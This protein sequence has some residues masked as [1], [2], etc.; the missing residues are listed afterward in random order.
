MLFGHHNMDLGKTCYFLGIC[1]GESVDFLTR[2]KNIGN[3]FCGNHKYS[4]RKL[5]SS[6]TYMVMLH[7]Y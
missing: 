2:E 7:M 1:I 3:Y 6:S 4:F 5:L